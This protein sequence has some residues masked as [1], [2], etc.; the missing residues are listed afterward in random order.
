[1]PTAK[2][3]MPRRRWRRRRRA[4]TPRR[5]LASRQTVAATFDGVIAKRFHNPGDLVEATASDPV[6][7]VIDP[8]RLQVDASVAISDLSRI[9]MGATGRLIVSTDAAAAAAEG[10][11]A[12]GR[13]R[14]GNGRGAGAPQLRHAAFACGRHAG[15]GRD[16]CGGAHQRRARSRRGDR[17]RRRGDGGVRGDGQ[18]GAAPAGG[19]SASST[20]STP[21]SREGVK[22]GEQVIVHGQAGLPDGATIT[23]E[24]PAD[25]KPAGES[26]EAAGPSLT[27]P[28]AGQMN[29]AA[30]RPSSFARGRARGR[31]AGRGRR[32]RRL[33][34]AEQH[35][36]PARV[37]AHR[38][39]RQERHAA[40]AVDD[41]DGD[42]AARAGGD[43]SA[44][45]PPR[46]LAK[47]SRRRGDLRAV[48]SVHRHGR[49][50]AAGAEPRGGDSRRTAGRHRAARSSG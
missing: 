33:L 38:H 21:R 48:R 8:A 39:H 32:H 31:R 24:K 50:A 29:V 20:R 4:A 6:L 45:H 15:A 44:R 3:R 35:L 13:R 1:M 37:P 26:R 43:G 40:A 9:V 28:A 23:T 5:Q 16:R 18:Q 49:G 10:G 22:A 41:A 17:P 36:S 12:A 7:R 19:A 47:H 14:A 2:W 27:K 42:A 34:A 11:L 30:T 25:E 46:A